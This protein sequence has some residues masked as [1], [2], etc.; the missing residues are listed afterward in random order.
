[1]NGF[2][3][4]NKGQL[5]PRIIDNSLTRNNTI[6]TG[7]GKSHSFIGMPVEHQ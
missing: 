5:L 4:N 2:S 1:V 7:A 6:E 3:N